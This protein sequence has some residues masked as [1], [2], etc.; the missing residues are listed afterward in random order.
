MSIKIPEIIERK[1]LQH[2]KKCYPAEACGLLAGE[3][4]TVQR[5]FRIRNIAREPH[6][7]LMEPSAQLRAFMQM[8][9][10]GLRLLAIYHSHPL[11]LPQPS[12]R[13]MQQN[14]YPEVATII[15]SLAEGSWNVHAFRMVKKTYKNVRLIWV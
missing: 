6:Q 8:E 2:V 4:A 11:D 15:W 5:F 7:F 9:R 3:Q 13:D 10:E 14:Y 12:R 1:M